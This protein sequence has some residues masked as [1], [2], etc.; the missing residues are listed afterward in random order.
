MSY[1]AFHKTALAT[2]ISL[3]PSISCAQ[4]VFG[5]IVASLDGVERTWFL[6]AQD[7]DSQSFGLTIAIANLQSFT[8]WGQPSAD[9]VK[10][11][12]DSLLLTFDIM[13]VAGQTIPASLSVIYLEDGWK[14]G[15]ISDDAENI[16]FE[17]TTL[18]KTGAG[19]VLEGSFATVANYREPLS[20]GEID[21][22]RTMQINARFKATLPPFT[23]MEK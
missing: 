22:S 18:E 9:D 15:W 2:A 11:M 10:T 23:L 16:T 3:A 4:E 6:T 14:S 19:V 5:T 1:S 12:Q 8:L 13:S 21:T 20:S 7:D 17:L